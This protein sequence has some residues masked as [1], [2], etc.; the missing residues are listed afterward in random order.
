MIFEKLKIIGTFQQEISLQVVTLEE[1]ALIQRI[2]L[3]YNV[4]C[5][6][7]KCIMDSIYSL[8]MNQSSRTKLFFK[9]S[10]RLVKTHNDVITANETTPERL[11]FTISNVDSELWPLV[12]TQPKMFCTMVLAVRN[13]V[14][15]TTKTMKQ[16][17]HPFCGDCFMNCGSFKQINRQMEKKGRRH[18]L[19]TWWR[20]RSIM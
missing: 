16:L 19:N 3:K 10:P 17:D 11:N 8:F 18:P 15:M 9:C 20:E 12:T 7:T 2:K 6:G 5:D 1:E 13:K 14:T 4:I